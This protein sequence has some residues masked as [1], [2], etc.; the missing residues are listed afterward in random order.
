M[1]DQP[2]TWKKHLAETLLLF[3]VGLCSTF[4]FC[5]DCIARI[6]YTWDDFLYSGLLWVFLWK[7]NEFVADIPDRYIS[8]KER[9]TQRLFIGIIGHVVYTLIASMALYQFISFLEDG[10]FQ[11]LSFRQIVNY[12]FTAVIVTLIIT[13]FLTAR[14]FLFSWR[15]LA[16]AHEQLKSE[17]VASRLASLKAQVNPHFLFNSLN[18]LSGLV[19][20]DADLSARFIKK[21]SEV[22][23]Y[24]LDRQEDE[25]VP[26]AEEVEFVEAVVFLQRI[27]FGEHLHVELDLPETP[28]LLVAPLAL[29]MLIE[30]AI[31][32]NAISADRPL[33]IRIFTEGDYLVVRNNLQP[34]NTLTES[35]G[36]GLENIKKRY[37]FLSGKAVIVTQDTDHF[38]VKLPIIKVA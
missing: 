6:E 21:L 11:T 16:V 4:L 10:H 15:D 38:T 13:L 23:R 2:K 19:Y 28:D 17:S 22:Y 24:V 9:P 1:A 36:I 37:S 3:A 20:R 7:G 31:K 33:T 26:L 8:W 32:H 35:L 34:K 14:S 30:N 12:N 25:L 5:R 27:R 18:V 29:Q